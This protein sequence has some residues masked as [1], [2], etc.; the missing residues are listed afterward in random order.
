MP[1]L[2]TNRL[3]GKP[4]WGSNLQSKSGRIEIKIATFLNLVSLWSDSED[5]AADISSNVKGRLE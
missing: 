5:E 2:D 1:I 4:G 3:A